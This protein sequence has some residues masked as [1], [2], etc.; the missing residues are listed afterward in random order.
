MALASV[1]DRVFTSVGGISYGGAV[2]SSHSCFSAWI[3]MQRWSVVSFALL[4]LWWVLQLFRLNTTSYT[5]RCS[6]EC[7]GI[8]GTDMCMQNGTIRMNLCSMEC[9]SSPNCLLLN[10]TAY[11]KLPQWEAS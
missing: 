8:N 5:A 7:G 3:I 1:L 11:G 2:G 10:A 9:C 6:S 4:T